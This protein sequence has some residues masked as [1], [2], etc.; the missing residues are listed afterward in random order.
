MNIIASKEVLEKTY[1]LFV[2]IEKQRDENYDIK[3]QNKLTD[4][5][6][7]SMRKDLKQN[8]KRLK[9]FKFKIISPGI[10]PGEVID[11]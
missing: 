8:Y 7:I 2:Y 9:G 5:I 3:E 6:I 11:K 10:R 1:S 4:E